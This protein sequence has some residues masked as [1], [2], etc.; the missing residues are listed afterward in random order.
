MIIIHHRMISSGFRESLGTSLFLPEPN[1]M[2]VV[3]NQQNHSRAKYEQFH[4]FTLLGI[5]RT[6]NTTN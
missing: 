2:H 6:S 1:M 3:H 4:Y 5:D